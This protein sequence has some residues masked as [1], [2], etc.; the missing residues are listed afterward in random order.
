MIKK[1]TLILAAIALL[2]GAGPTAAQTDGGAQQALGYSYLSP[3]PG[4]Q[5]CTPQTCFV[6]MRLAALPP[7]AITNLA[8][9]IQVS[10]ASSGLHLGTTRIAS[11]NQTVIFFTPSGF[12]Q[13]EPVTVTLTPLVDLTTNTAIPPYQYQFMVSGP[14][15]NAA[16]ITASAANA[17]TDTA[18]MAFDDNLSTEW[19]A[20]IVP[21]GTTNFAWIQYLYPGGALHVVNRY[22]LTSANDNPAGDPAGWQF[23]GVTASSNLVLLDTE[24]AQTFS[25]RL[26]PQAYGFT[27][28]AAYRGYRL[29]V[30]RVNNP[31]TAT[32]VQLA[33]LELIPATGS[34]LWE[35]WTNLA[36]TAVS[37]LTSSPLY[38]AYPSLTD[39]LPSFCGPVNWA[40]NYGTRVYGY[41]TAPNTGAYQF[42][43]AGDDT[44][45]LWFS[46]NAN[47]AN[48]GLIASVPGYTAPQVWNTY[49][50]QQSV[51][52]TLQAG[53]RC[54][55]EARH[56]QG[57]GGNNLAVGW[58]MPG[59]SLSAP[60]E[61]IPG[62]VL[63][64]GTPVV[65]APGVIV[66]PQ[67]I[68]AAA[69]LN[70]QMSATAAGT[71]P[72]AYQWQ[73]NSTNLLNGANFSG[74]NSN[75]LTILNV[76]PADAGS[77][78][79]IVTNPYGSATSSNAVLSVVSPSLVGEWLA[80]AA[81]WTEISG[82]SPPG[83][84]DG[85]LVGAGHYLFTN[86]VPA[87]KSGQSLWLPNGDT[88]I[89]ISNS[90]TLDLHYTNTFDNQLA[91]AFTLTFWAKGFPTGWAY[92]IS[93][94][95]DSGSPNSGWTFRRQGAYG[96]NNPCWTLRSPG[97]TLVLGADSYGSTDDLG[98]S[99]LNLADGN[100]HFYVGAYTLGGNRSLY[101]D[102][103]L[104]AQETGQGAYNSSALEHL[105]IG[106]I[107]DSPGNSFGSFFTG[108]FYDVRVYNY[109]LSLTPQPL[110]AIT[111]AP[112]SR[113]ESSPAVTTP[114]PVPALPAAP[115]APPVTAVPLANSLGTPA[116]VTPGQD[117]IMPNGVSVPT[118]FPYLNITT[119]N[120]PDPEFIFIDNRG[121]NGDPW[122]VIFD[123]SGQPVWYAKYPDE[124][125][126]MVVQHNGVLTML[127]RDE[128][129]D[130]YNG[131]NTNY[132][133]IVQ[134]WTTNGYSGD[135]HELQVLAD[136]TYFTT[137]LQT[138]TVDM[139]RYIAGGQTNASVTEGAIQ[140]FTAAGDLIM[141]WRAWDHINILDEQAFIDL[142]SSS[143]DFTHM[144]SIDADTDGN[145]LLSSRNTSEC[146]KIDRNTGAIIWR[147]GGVHSSFTFPND[148]L[149]GPRNQHAFRMVTTNDYTLFDDGN[150]HNPSVSRGVEYVVNTNTMTAAVVWQYPPV[151]NTSLYAYYMG[152]A[153]RLTNGNTL[154]DWAVGGLPKLTEIAPD[155]S[156]AYEMNWANQYEAYRTW[157]CTWHGV[158][159][160]PYLLL[161][162]YPDNVTL[163]F[164]QFGDT[165]VAYY[166][167]Y[168]GPTSHS[169][170]FLGNSATTLARLTYL[171]NGVTYYFRTVAVHR[172][173]TLGQFS[174]EQS[175]NVN[176]IQPGQNMVTNGG[177]TLGTN[178]W[179]L[180]L[181]HSG[182]VSAWTIT[183]GVS[184][185][186]IANAGTYTTDIQLYQTGFRLI[187]GF[188]YTLAFDAWA[189]RPRYIQAEV[190]QAVSPY[191]NYSSLGASALTP[192]RTH[193]QYVFTMTQ[194]SDFN[195]S[196]LF[197][198]GTSSAG[199]SLANVSLA[200]APPT[201]A[202]LLTWVQPPAGA[203]AGAA[204]APEIKVGA[205]NET[206]PV[207]GLPITLFITNGIGVLAGIQTTNTDTNG[208][209]HFPN[210]SFSQAGP[211]QLAAVNAALVIT[212]AV[213]A[214]T[215]P[216]AT[217]TALS[218]V[219]P[220]AN[221]TAGTVIS[222]EIQVAA[223]T[224]SLPVT[225]A[226]L[227]LSLANGTGT[228]AGVLATNTDVNG[229]A[230]FPNVSIN[231][232]GLKQ[233]AAGDATATLTTTSAGFVISA[234]TPNKLVLAQSPPANAVAGV[235]LSPAPVVQV[236]DL[237]GNVISNATDTISAVQTGGTGGNLN[238]TPAAQSVAASSGTATFSGLFVTNAT[239]NVSLGFTDASLP[240]PGVTSSGINVSANAAAGL[241]V[242]QQPASAAVVGANFAQQ[243]VVTVTDVYGNTA[244]SYTSAVLAAETAGGNLNA[245]PVAPAALPAS[246]IATF[247]GLFVTNAGPA[248]TLDFTSGGLP[249]VNSAAINV[250]AGPV[251]QLIWSTEP[252]NA[253]AGLPFGLQPVLQTA[254]LFDNP[255]TNGLAAIQNVQ[256]FL[257][258]GAGPLLGTTNY[259]IG[260]A[261]S[262]GVVS[263]TDL[264]L[265][266]PGVNDVLTATNTTLNSLT[267][268]ATNQ[269][270]LWL[271]ASALNSLTVSAGNVTAWND[272]SGHGRNASGGVPPVLATNSTLTA[273]ALGLGRVVRFNGSSTYLNV[274]LT[275]LNETP[276]TIAILEVASSKGGSSSYFLGDTGGGGN[277]TDN[278][279]HT[280]YR[281]SGDYTFAHYS[282]DLD[283]VPAGGFTYPAARVWLDVIDSGKN[284][285]IYLNGAAVATM[286]AAG[287]L[288]SAGS[289]GHVGSGFDTS[290]TCFQG[291]IAEILVYTNAQNAIVA[292]LTSYLSNKW[293]CAGC[294]VPAL[295]NG[296]SAP[297]AVQ[298]PAPPSQKILGATVAA[299]G[300][301][302]LT[303]A[304][305]AG[306]PYHVQFTTNLVLG[307]WT[308]LPASVTNAMG[309]S[310]TFTDTNSPGS[311]QRFYRIVSP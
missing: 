106:G 4:A 37:N 238:A 87:G 255:S 222:P 309:T 274:D 17:P 171:Q 24:T 197:D 175:V 33:E 221:A 294:V 232:A 226:L 295:A 263:F 163:L 289:Q 16:V 133:Q 205:Y 75:T 15:T 91:N 237:Y 141:Q 283:F 117:G 284:K 225:N 130:H 88:G 208:I 206:F 112:S 214:I 174:N 104:V 20:P 296:V 160:Q 182:S 135:E 249:P 43:I 254:D 64:P 233:L 110:A 258:A 219:Q 42:W 103:V 147:L 265:N 268:P 27:N 286:T 13:Y 10:G 151:P 157:R 270:G 167:I 304:T 74:V 53:Q 121:G 271:D 66:P 14:N 179:V 273:G 137:A 143:L 209:A 125:R 185:F 287:F 113:P 40:Q 47:P 311:A 178:G 250:G 280:G 30:T 111:P 81:N 307:A 162:S 303:Y 76:V 78:R 19:Q 39:Q 56:K 79:L 145:I 246:G 159:L 230:H 98:T 306:F 301:V 299:G 95:G 189:S 154:I 80:G 28:T 293:L 126:D 50:S 229:I 61:V 62:E 257:S 172:D 51:P 170:N 204:I 228:L 3:V 183:N 216:P 18:A 99:T 279:L 7:T 235:V 122:N 181:A 243:P 260:S 69:G 132:Q 240:H 191:L 129:G 247:S 202:T 168:G 48:A 119:S 120:N 45:E 192:V 108:E 89:A 5:Y 136:G 201:T 44:S 272:L 239:A 131:F 96:N 266:A 101:V 90:S 149:T 123:N 211:K 308:T 105:V 164:N 156:K 259:N 150:L 23:Y 277:S 276:Y 92:F 256:V 186:I 300:A 278:A 158:A 285:T 188:T 21:N 1:N 11:D 55:L 302:V 8:Q 60:S 262:N 82:Y 190:G 281:S 142:T 199:V 49:A 59:Q 2:A 187:Q 196:L 36:G 138:E 244:A 152:N 116:G 194:P 245:T 193:F 29:L 275:F 26:Q 77:Y 58:A 218:F 72:L 57:G 70:A 32:S 25:S 288:N 298:A 251:A 93:K 184:S 241:A 63:S 267:P 212:S 144:N 107:D 220:P 176:L 94:N 231:L 155:G 292:G 115:L 46:T 282:D 140:E 242:T 261:G 248:V 6:L 236:T 35:C 305:T 118:D 165:N 148:P 65:V 200:I 213:F 38:P 22:A 139:S 173:G 109:D 73:L 114:R 195:A 84:H 264:R 34:L 97:G 198:L 146:T 153:Q 83:T 68:T 310:I 234:T 166:S 207:A 161:E 128:G 9:C 41:V 100:W 203:V 124:R 210:L 12:N 297:F 224:N 215:T 102:G 169:T 269:L 52:F 227:T 67:S 252:G 71:A 177:F 134:Y 290:S 127:A 223:W 180:A 54:Y 253:I 85:Y 86:D 217:A 291:D 31:A